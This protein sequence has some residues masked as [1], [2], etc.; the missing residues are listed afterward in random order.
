MQLPLEEAKGEELIN[1]DESGSDDD[2]TP[3]SERE[4]ALLLSSCRDA[5][6]RVALKRA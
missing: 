6:L 4:A 1:S 3:D 5:R 2:D